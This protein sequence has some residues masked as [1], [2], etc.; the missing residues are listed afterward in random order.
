M[1]TYDNFFRHIGKFSQNIYDQLPSP[2]HTKAANSAMAE[3][4]EGLEI[5]SAVELGCGSAPCLDYL[6]EHGVKTLGVTIGKEDCNHEVLRED[7]HFSTIPDGSYDLVI[8]RHALEHSPIPLILLAEMRRISKNYAIVIV[9]TLTQ[10]MVNYTNHYSVFPDFVWERLFVLSG[11][12]IKKFRA[13]NYFFDPD[14][15]WDSEYRYL[16]KTV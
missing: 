10:R 14:K 16:L 6:K 11:W 5:N 13:E 3:L 8:A 12:A 4:L 2:H 7:M 1:P 9:P 15:T